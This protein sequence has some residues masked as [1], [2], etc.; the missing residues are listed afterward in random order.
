LFDHVAIPFFLKGQCHEINNL[1]E[2]LRFFASS[3]FR[4]ILFKVLLA[5]MK[6]LTNFRDFIESRI[7]ILP[8][9]QQ[10]WWQLREL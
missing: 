4:K 3:L 2:G 7:R 8:T 6:T 5:S 10:N 9:P 1:F